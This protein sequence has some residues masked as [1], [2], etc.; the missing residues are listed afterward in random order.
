[1]VK[2]V[3]DTRINQFHAEMWAAAEAE[4]GDMFKVPANVAADI[5]EKVRALYVVQVWQKQTNAG[6]ALKFLRSYSVAEDAIKY[7]AENFLDKKELVEAESKD[8]TPKRADRWRA[9]EDWAK[10][11]FLEEVTTEQMVEVAGFSYPTVLNYLKTS[12]YFR[13]IK[14]GA[15]EVR[16]PKADRAREKNG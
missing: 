16:D 5:S 2:T 4:H 7:V 3:N 15:W 9:L 1:M 14:R 11:H 10:Q 6:S 12:P 13:K 8:K